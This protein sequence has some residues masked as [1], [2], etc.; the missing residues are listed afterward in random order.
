MSIAE[1]CNKMYGKTIRECSNE[2][3]YTALLALVKKVTEERKEAQER[4]EK[5]NGKKVYYI[6]AEFLIGR[7]IYNN[8]LNLGLLDQLAELF[9]ENGIEL[10][11]FEDIEDPALGNGGLGR[12]AACFLDSAATHNIPLN[13]YGIRYKYGLFKQYF[14]NGF[15]RE[16]ADDWQRFGDPWSIRRES[17]KVLVEFKNQQVYAVPYDMPVIGYGG[18]RINTL[19]LW[20]AEPVC[21]KVSAAEIRPCGAGAR[22]SRGD[23]QRAVSKRRYGQRKAPAFETAIFLLQRIP[24]GYPAPIQTEAW[25]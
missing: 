20:Q 17:E 16:T 12:L 22:R 4:Q 6:S 14:E 9:N 8:L 5:E 24:P 25:E 11:I 13:G 10:S 1:I 23:F 15:Q 7:L 21:A 18:K 3:V 2:Q 19:R